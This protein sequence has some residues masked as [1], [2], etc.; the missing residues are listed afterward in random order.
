MKTHF[1]VAFIDPPQIL[2]ASVTNIPGS[3]S[4][5]LQIIADIGPLS[6]F[7]VDFMD[8]TGDQIG[9][10]RGAPGSEILVGILGNGLTG[11]M[12][13]IFSAHCRVSIRSMTSTP[14]TNGKLVMSMMSERAP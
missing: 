10:Y 13:G 6:A 9:V 12:Y 3:G 8:T 2:D 5:P 4:L 7:S 14:I 11:T 1:P